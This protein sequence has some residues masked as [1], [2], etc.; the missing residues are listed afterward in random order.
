MV[1]LSVPGNERERTSGTSENARSRTCTPPAAPHAADLCAS[2]QLVF[3]RRFPAVGETEH[4]ARPEWAS[5]RLCRSPACQR[6]GEA[7]M[8]GRMTRGIVTKRAR[9]LHCR[10]CSPWTNLSSGRRT[11]PCRPLTR[12]DATF[13]AVPTPASVTPHPRRPSHLAGRSTALHHFS[14]GPADS[15]SGSAA[16]RPVSA[17]MQKPTRPGHSKLGTRIDGIEEGH[18]ASLGRALPR[19]V[20]AKEARVHGRAFRALHV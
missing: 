16:T 12:A 11:I 3:S 18:W 4:Q 1:S 19:H 13:V 20:R 15:E 5:R 17:T 8:P 7:S 10:P 2:R 6:C 14:F 9:A